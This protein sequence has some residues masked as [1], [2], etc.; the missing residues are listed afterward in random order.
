MFKKIKSN[1]DE[2]ICRYCEEAIPENDLLDKQILKSEIDNNPNDIS[3]NIISMFKENLE[4]FPEKWGF[5]YFYEQLTNKKIS[6][7]KHCEINSIPV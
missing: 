5:D 7:H 3:K 4:R 1:S 2:V 6:L